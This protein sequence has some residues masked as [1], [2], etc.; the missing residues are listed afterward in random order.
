MEIIMQEQ[1]TQMLSI[2]SNASM[3]E[4]Q[5]CLSTERDN[6]ARYQFARDRARS[7]SWAN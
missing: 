5:T 4:T 2:W 1:F 3:E 6:T 7:I